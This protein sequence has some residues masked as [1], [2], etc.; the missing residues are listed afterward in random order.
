MA[1]KPE[2]EQPENGASGLEIDG[3]KGK[4]PR[5][6]GEYLE[7]D[8]ELI[9]HTLARQSQETR[10]GHRKRLGELL[11]EEK[12]VT[13]EVLQEALLEQRLDRLQ[14]CAL[15]S[16]ISFDELAK[17]RNWVSEVSVNQGEEFITQDVPGDCFYV[18]MTG[19]LL[20]YRRGEYGEEIP[21]AHIEPGE[22]V[23]EMGYFS[24][25]HRS[26]SVKALE[27]SQLLK[28][29]YADLEK[30]FDRAPTLTRNFLR[31][32]VERLLHTDVRLQEIAI[33]RRK[34][35]RSLEGL[36]KLL[37]MSEII[38]LQTGI[39]GLIER[40]VTTAST[41]MNAE[42]SSLFLLDNFAGELWSKV[43]TGVE[44]KEIRIP[45]G[46]G[47]AGWVAEH[48]EFVNI[49]DAYDDPRFDTSVDLETGYRTK[50]I[51]CGPVKNLMGETI[52]V[53]QVINKKGGIFREKDEELFSVFVYQTAIAVENFR[54]Y[55][56]VITYH[57]K[58]A[59]LLD[60]TTSVAQTLDL[61]ALILKIV[62]KISQ[63]LDAERSSLFMLDTETDEL[64]SKV[65]HRS[66]VVE[67]RFPSSFGLA[68]FSVSTGQILNI[69][70]AYRDPRFN[71][72][73]DRQTGYRT[74]TVLCA[75]IIN[76][77]GETIGVTQAI[78]K[79]GG[80]FDQED[81]DLIK[82]LASQLSV[83]LENAQL[84]EEVKSQ[85]EELRAKL[86]RIEMLEKVKTQLTK[87]VPTSV[88]DLVERDPDKL[89]L[90]KVSMDVSILF[91]DIEGFATITAEHDEML[92][93]E[94][95]E[96]HFS[97]YLDCI[98]RYGGEVN[99]TTGDGLMIIFK[100]NS[101][102]ENNQNVVAA[103]K[104]IVSENKRLN[105]ELKFP[106][107]KIDLHLGIN[108]GKAWVGSTKLKSLSGERWTY[109]ASGLVT[110]MAARIGALSRGS[111]IYIGPETQRCLGKSY[112]CEFIGPRDFKNI[113][114][115]VP[116]YEVKGRQKD[117]SKTTG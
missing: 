99:E 106:W 112:H 70:D 50:T 75:P 17:I 83:S 113:K 88:A 116:I 39:E 48:D 19:Q 44:T 108:S 16:G 78:N 7:C 91:I 18:L 26:A 25:G 109:T 11:V 85:S 104:E 69:R 74:N 34:A 23:G 95:V 52:G 53:I 62:E 67:I 92:V 33:G 27:E 30:I 102:E 73:V 80:E 42:R 1:D 63:A 100:G 96:S 6:L 82:S 114:T 58:M 8:S 79:R 22:G 115:P 111:R 72:A 45:L 97:A 36:F 107:G 71:P 77:K 94:M 89:A 61:D 32:V 84:Y 41:V 29:N 14:C 105:D 47:V 49:K 117:H 10:K 76:R 68:G 5:R 93:N 60:V 98:S 38:A 86:M 12:A 40:I 110:V 81:E 46:K 55:Q 101:K 43:A 90:E 15:F 87:F 2:D 103:A 9:G 59:V 56:K 21:L 28:I 66:E 20:V 31:L 57:G 4:Q 64:W 37:D 3:R 54:L 51:L 24:G 35:E 65:A 13:P